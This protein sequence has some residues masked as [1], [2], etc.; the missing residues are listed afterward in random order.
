MGPAQGTAG[1]DGSPR[2]SANRERGERACLL[3]DLSLAI[4]DGARRMSNAEL[5]AAL[6]AE[7]DARRT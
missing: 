4:G 5:A 2:P 7:L 3:G 6:R 1:C